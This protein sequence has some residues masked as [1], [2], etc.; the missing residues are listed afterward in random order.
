MCVGFL[1]AVTPFLMEGCRVCE[2]G[3]VGFAPL[4]TLLSSFCLL[5]LDQGFVRFHGSDFLGRILG[6]ALEDL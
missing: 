5:G 1:G 4:S 6:E 2:V 3:G